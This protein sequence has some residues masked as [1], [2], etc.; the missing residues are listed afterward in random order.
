MFASPADLAE[1]AVTAE[2]GHNVVAALPPC[3]A[4]APPCFAQN[5]S[6]VSRACHGWFIVIS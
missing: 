2:R 6:A 3:A 1:A 4:G 5:S